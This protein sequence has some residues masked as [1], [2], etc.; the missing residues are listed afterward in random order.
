MFPNEVLVW[1]LAALGVRCTPDSGL[2]FQTNLE[3]VWFYT[4]NRKYFQTNKG[5]PRYIDCRFNFCL[6][7]LLNFQFWPKLLRKPKQ[8]KTHVILSFFFYFFL[9]RND[10]TNTILLNGKWYYQRHSEKKKILESLKR[11]QKNIFQCE[12]INSNIFENKD[13]VR[14]WKYAE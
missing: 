4:F 11:L 6:L 5:R 10:I 2:F 14:T 12:I 3:F 9:T 1:V 7:D 8:F 13:I